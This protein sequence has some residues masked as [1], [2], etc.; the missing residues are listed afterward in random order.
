MACSQQH[1]QPAVLTP[2][3]APCLHHP[4]LSSSSLLQNYLKE[5]AQLHEEFKASDVAVYGVCAQEQPAV[6]QAIKD[7]EL[8]YE[9]SAPLI[10]SSPLP[11]RPPHTCSGH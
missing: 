4:L 9:A 6:D 8:N 7:W 2:V 1:Y 5:F 11:P 3:M 10:L